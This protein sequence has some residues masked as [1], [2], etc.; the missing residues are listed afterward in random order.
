MLFA[1]FIR[2]RDGGAAPFLALAM[3]PLMGFMGAAVDYSRANSA[4]TA[5]QTALDATALALSK[6]A[7]GMAAGDLSGKTNELFAALFN[8]PE[9]L[10]AAVTTEFLSPQDGSFILKLTGS[11]KVNT[12]FSQLIGQSQISFTAK[13][14][15]LWGI[16]KLN[17]ALALDNTGSM[18]SSGKMSALKTAAHNLLN[19]LKDAEKTPGDIKVSIVPFAVAVNVGTEKVNATWIRWDQ[20]DKDNGTCSKS[21]Y[22]TYSS[23]VSNGKVWTP[24]SHSLWNGCV[25]DRDQNYDVL[26]TAP[27]GSATRFPAD[28]ATHCPVA[29]MPLSTNWSTLHGKIDEMTPAGNTNVTIG[30]QMA[31]Q[32]LADNAPFDAPSPAPDLDKV[33]I[34]LTDGDNTENRWTTSTSSINARTQKVCDNIKAASIRIYTVRVINGNATL[35][36]NCATNP[37]MYYDVDQADELNGVFSS[38]AQNLANLRIAK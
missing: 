5:M 22:T 4:R 9:V 23:C 2:N 34:L 12:V 24:K 3:L 13:S 36:R 19:T 8:R 1:R 25:N 27:S 28:Q 11:G 20:W 21:S 6:T 26:A 16:K 18:S 35:L 7:Q 38:I 14:E 30:L 37:N 33:I 31:W 17:L 29:M 15:V 10:D 32:T